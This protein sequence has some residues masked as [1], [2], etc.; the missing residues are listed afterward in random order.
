MFNLYLLILGIY[1]LVTKEMKDHFSKIVYFFENVKKFSDNISVNYLYWLGRSHNR[2]SLP[3]CFRVS[4]TLY[5]IA[6]YK[7]FVINTL[8]VKMGSHRKRPDRRN[9]CVGSCGED[10]SSNWCTRWA[11]G[12]AMEPTETATSCTAASDAIHTNHFCNEKTNGE[13]RIKLRSVK[14]V[15]RYC[16]FRTL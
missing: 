3:Y 10:A 9:R 7:K 12:G 1:F 4:K 14:Y 16:Y 6:S 8:L 2:V 5:Y 13:R 15:I 11:R